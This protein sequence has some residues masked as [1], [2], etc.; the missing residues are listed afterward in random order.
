MLFSS[1]KSSGRDGEHFSGKNAELL[2][3]FRLCRA[4]GAAGSGECLGGTRAVT[5]AAGLTAEPDISS[6]VTPFT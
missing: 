1:N 4:F 6:I 5:A 3:P 2:A